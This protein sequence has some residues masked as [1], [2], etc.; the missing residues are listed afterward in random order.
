MASFNESFLQNTLFGPHFDNDPFADRPIF[1]DDNPIPHRAL[2]VREFRQQETIYTFLLPA[3]SP[4]MNP[5]EYLWDQ[6]N[7]QCQNMAELTNAIPTREASSSSS[8]H[9]LRVRKLWCK[10]GGYTLYWVNMCDKA[11]LYI[12]A[13]ALKKIMFRPFS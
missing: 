3:L 1:M 7:Q 10:H 13:N 4:D 11:S 2:V 9:A 12:H 6:R 5:T 8:W